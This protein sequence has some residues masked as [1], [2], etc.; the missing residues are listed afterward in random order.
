[1]KTTQQKKPEEDHPL[2][3]RYVIY[4]RKDRG[5]AENSVLIYKSYVRQLLADEGA[6]TSVVTAQAFDTATVRNFLLDR[7]RGRSGEYVRLLAVAL[8]SFLRFL[9][10]SGELPTDLSV[11]APAFL[12]P[13]ETF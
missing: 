1:V 11:A 13:D 2:L 12:S 3:R 10:F 9:F 6:R 5:L 4:L 7:S 8:R